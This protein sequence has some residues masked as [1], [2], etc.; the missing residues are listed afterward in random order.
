[1]L[2]RIR[3]HVWRGCTR[4]CAYLRAFGVGGDDTPHHHAVSDRPHSIAGRGMGEVGVPPPEPT[5]ASAVW[6]QRHSHRTDVQHNCTVETIP[7]P[8]GCYTVGMSPVWQPH[9]SK[10]GPSF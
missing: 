6:R 4:P 2:L 5:V 7:H 1:M 9:P 3:C 8:M 10:E